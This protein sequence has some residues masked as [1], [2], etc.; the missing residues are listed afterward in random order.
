[1]ETMEAIQ[2]RRSI[3]RF[4]ADLVPRDVIERLLDL[5]IRA[6]SAKNGQPW[7]FVVTTGEAK[8]RLVETLQEVL[9]ETKSK[10]QP[11]GS[12][13][14]SIQAM[15]EAPVVILVFNR[16]SREDIPEP[17]AYAKLL[18]DTQSLGAAIQTFLLA[19][20]DMGL[21]T[22]W[23]CDVL[24]ARCEVQAFASTKEELMAA[25]ALGIPAETPGERPRQDWRELS[26]WME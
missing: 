7:R 18:V 11:T 10:G 9:E 19:A 17:Y 15:A 14:G 12:L 16:L 26:T 25:I 21:G 5:T 8:S 2:G 1:M 22:L 13:Q 24:Y 6:P 4:K 23:I 20:Q 3:R